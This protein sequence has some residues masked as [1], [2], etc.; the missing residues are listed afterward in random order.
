MNLSF[1][2]GEGK[3]RGGGETETPTIE[4]IRTVMSQRLRREIVYMGWPSSNFH[5][6]GLKEKVFV[7]AYW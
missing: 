5:F 2:L 1:E 7:S 3:I 4:K 6:L